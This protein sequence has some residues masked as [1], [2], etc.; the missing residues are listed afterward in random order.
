[1]SHFRLVFPCC[2]SGF[3]RSVGFV[4]TLWAVSPVVVT[5]GCLRVLSAQM[6]GRSVPRL[7]LMRRVSLRSGCRWCWPGPLSHSALGRFSSSWYSA[8]V[9]VHVPLWPAALQLG[10]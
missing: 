4:G 7:R 6:R 1:M 10:L 5:V 2:L 3:A 9:R 8:S